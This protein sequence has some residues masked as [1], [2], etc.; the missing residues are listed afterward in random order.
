[1]TY[2]DDLAALGEPQTVVT[3]DVNG[4]FPGAR[5]REVIDVHNLTDHEFV[6][7]ETEDRT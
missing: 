7:L 1:M 5:V 4:T 6:E 2:I 3:A